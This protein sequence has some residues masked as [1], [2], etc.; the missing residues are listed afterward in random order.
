MAL[1]EKSADENDMASDLEEVF[2]ELAIESIQA[3]M[4]QRDPDFDGSNCLDCTDPIPELRLKM[5][6]IRCV[7]CQT[8]I[9]RKQKGLHA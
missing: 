8:V 9:E 2:R 6:R 1:I 4:V 3:N 7:D 5:G